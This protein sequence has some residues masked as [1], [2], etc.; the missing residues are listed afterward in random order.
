MRR[1]RDAGAEVVVGTCPDLGTI[2]PIAPPLRQ[3]ARLWSRR[4]AAAQTIATVEAGGRTVS[5]G[6]VLGAGVRRDARAVLRPGPV[7]PLRGR[8]LHARRRCC[9]PRCWPRSA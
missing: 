9:C 3:V 8:L 7:P 2:E 5:L 4:L 6:S 1:L